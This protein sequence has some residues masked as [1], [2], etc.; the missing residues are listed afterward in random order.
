MVSFL[1][2]VTK[3]DKGGGVV[4]KEIAKK[5]IALRGERT[6]QQVA[7]AVGVSQSAIL[8]YEYGYRVPKDE[9]KIRIA[10]YYQVSVQDLFFSHRP[11]VM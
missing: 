9:I 11:H 10:D 8:M 1:R 5:L 7:D 3:Y 6:R 2:N 4:S